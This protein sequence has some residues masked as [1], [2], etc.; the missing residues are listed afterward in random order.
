[1]ARSTSSHSKRAMAAPSS[2]VSIVMIIIFVIVV[3]VVAKIDVQG[4]EFA[5]I[6]SFI[7]LCIFSFHLFLPAVLSI[8]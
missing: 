8:C 3:V 2:S 6:F 1:M 5:I 4:D 7:S